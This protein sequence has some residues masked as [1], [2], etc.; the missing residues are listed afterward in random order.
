[1][2]EINSNKYKNANDISK[3]IYCVSQMDLLLWQLDG[4]MVISVTSPLEWERGILLKSVQNACSDQKVIFSKTK[5]PS[6]PP[7]LLACH[8]NGKKLPVTLH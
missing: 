3:E 7:E 5:V 2:W 8:E 6:H 4:I 1:M